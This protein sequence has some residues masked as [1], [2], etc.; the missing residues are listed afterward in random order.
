MPANLTPE[1]MEAEKRYR[2]SKTPEEKLACLEEMLSKIPKHKGT[3]KMQANIKRKISQFKQ[4]AE[5]QKRR[6]KGFSYKI[7]KEGSGQIALVGAPNVGK[8]ALLAH[9]THAEPEVAPYPFTT[10][11]PIPGMMPYLNVSIQ[12]MD[13]PPLSHEHTEPWTADMIKAADGVLMVCDLASSDPIEQMEEPVEVLRAFG[14]GLL[15]PGEPI[16]PEKRG[17]RKKALIV[18]NKIDVQGSREMWEIVREM[19][20]LP[21]PLLSVSA[22]TGEGLQNLKQNVYELLF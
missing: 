21:L 13:L 17:I 5:S 2:A 4:Q 19:K 11:T 12:L 15:A 14:I 16:E 22:T 1:Y 8:S 9:L 6:Q 18:A 3:E 20:E 10:H 7:P